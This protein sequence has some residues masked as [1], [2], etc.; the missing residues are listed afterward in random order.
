[1]AKVLF[2][3][4]SKYP[5]GNGESFVDKE[6]PFLVNTFDKI[7]I[8]SNNCIDKQT[9]NITQNAIIEKFPY[10]L[11]FTHTVLSLFN[12]FSPI[13]WHELNCIKKV[14]K[15]K[16]TTVMIKT[17]LISIQ[18]SKIFRKK[19]KRIIRNQCDANDTIIAYSYWAND[20]AFALSRMKKQY[21]QIKMIAR[22]HGWD[23]YFEANQANYLPFRK[24]IL[25]GLDRIFF[26]S[27]KGFDYYQKLFP[28]LVHKM[29]VARLGVPQQT[30]KTANLES[31]K[32][33]IVSC[34]NV[35]PL[36]RIHLISE[37][38]SNISDVPIEWTHFGNGSAFEN[39]QNQ[40]SRLLSDKTD[41]TYKLTG[42]IANSEVISFYQSN[43]VNL[44]INVS[45]TEGI[46]VSIMEAMS[47][48]VPVIATAVGGNPEIVKDGYNG[49]LLPKNP[50]PKEIAETIIRFYDLKDHEKIQFRENAYKTWE[51]DY[52]AEE[53]YKKFIEN[54][55]EL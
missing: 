35:I 36:K 28:E 53:N 9:R 2:F 6:I 39:L 13:F 12:C 21:P 34:S 3:F 1:M 11:S 32:L 24:P 26:I 47:F 29:E 49:L 17:A 4:T 8:I 15:K 51:Q 44:F 55:L 33:Q 31:E 40:C 16:C 5:F 50:T 54:I 14:Y 38:L 18:K 27:Q 20:T 43:A 48:G 45:S 46:P 22:A 41:I 7:V 19:I 42:Y 37:A 25:Q 10:E 52:N 23:V 30:T